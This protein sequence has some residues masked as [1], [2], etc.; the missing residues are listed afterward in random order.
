MEGLIGLLPPQ[1]QE[2]LFQDLMAAARSAGV[3]PA[4]WLRAKHAGLLQ[5]R[6]GEDGTLWVGRATLPVGGGV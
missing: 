2:M 5:T 3:N 6:I 1:G 4:L